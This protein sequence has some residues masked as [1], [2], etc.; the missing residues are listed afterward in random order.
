MIIIV[1]GID[2]VGKTTLCNKLSESLNFPIHKHVKKT[3]YKNMDNDNETD[4]MMQILDVCNQTHCNIIFDRFHLSEYVYGVKDRCYDVSKASKN[5][6]DVDN[7]LNDKNDVLL[8]LVE[9]VDIERSSLEHGSDLSMHKKIFDDIFKESCI[10]NKWK[11]TYNTLDEAEMFVRTII[12]K[13]M[14]D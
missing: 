9:P 5:L 10:K 8:I 7:M 14:N 12:N 11:C 13:I 1:E 3:L 6:L 2:R 4:K